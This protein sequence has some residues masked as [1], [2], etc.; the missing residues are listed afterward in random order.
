MHEAGFFDQRKVSIKKTFLSVR[1]KK[2][3]GSGSVKK[4]YGCLQA[5]IDLHSTHLV[6]G[7]FFHGRL[8]GFSGGFCTKDKIE[9]I[10]T[11]LD[12]KFFLHKRA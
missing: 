3:G 1:V 5:T 9:F 7:F 12:S 2:K 8:V 6:L 11:I 4:E 10:F